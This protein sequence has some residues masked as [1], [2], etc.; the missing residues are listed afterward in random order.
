MGR[1]WDAK[2]KPGTL[3]RYKNK[4]EARF[5]KFRDGQIQNFE[6][7]NSRVL[8]EAEGALFC[9]EP[10]AYSELSVASSEATAFAPASASAPATATAMAMAVATVMATVT[11]T[12][13]A[14]AALVAEAEA[15]RKEFYETKQIQGHVFLYGD[16]KIWISHYDQKELFKT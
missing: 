14:A 12:V 8:L 5:C 15:S 2:M 10:V 6:T 13:T 9:V 4:A 3:R 7:W 1:R 16:K 11:A